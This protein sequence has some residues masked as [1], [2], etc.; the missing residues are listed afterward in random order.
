MITIEF[1]DEEALDLLAIE[2]GKLDPTTVEKLRAEVLQR[3]AQVPEAE[4]KEV[5]KMSVLELPRLNYTEKEML[6]D[7]GPMGYRGPNY[8]KA[9]KAYRAR[10]KGVFLYQAK[11]M[12]DAYFS[13]SGFRGE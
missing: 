6:S 4:A 5:S 12:C 10:V 11:A 3:M 2:P 9:I 13:E 7:C 8:L 1:T